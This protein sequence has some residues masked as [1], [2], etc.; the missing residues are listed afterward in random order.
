M[1]VAILNMYYKTNKNT[2][3]KIKTKQTKKTK[4]NENQSK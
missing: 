4:P 1:V 2:K 3:K